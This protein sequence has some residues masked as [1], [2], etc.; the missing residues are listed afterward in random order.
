M[1]T[2]ASLRR[3]AH[4]SHVAIVAVNMLIFQVLTSGNFKA[5]IIF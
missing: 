1:T 3:Q 4:T 2:R 5:K